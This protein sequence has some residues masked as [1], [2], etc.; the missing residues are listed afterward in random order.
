MID[1]HGD[2]AIRAYFAPLKN[3][4]SNWVGFWLL[5]MATKCGNKSLGVPQ[6]SLGDRG[7]AAKIARRTASSDGFS[8]GVILVTCAVIS[9]LYRRAPDRT[10]LKPHPASRWLDLFFGAWARLVE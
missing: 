8:G 3:T 9:G 1:G 4:S 6:D 10:M 7:D 2:G 5:M